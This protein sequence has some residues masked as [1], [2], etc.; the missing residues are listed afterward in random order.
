MGVVEPDVDAVGDVW[1]PIVGVP[2]W[3]GILPG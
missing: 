3:F 1:N 2:G